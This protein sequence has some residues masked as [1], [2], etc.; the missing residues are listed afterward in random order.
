MARFIS[1]PR[2]M[3]QVYGNTKLG[4]VNLQAYQYWFPHALRAQLNG[5]V[6]DILILNE[7]IS[8]P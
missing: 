7:E 3:R 2:F 8:V 6:R 5:K 1:Q 4:T